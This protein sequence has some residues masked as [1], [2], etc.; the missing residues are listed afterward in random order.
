[1]ISQDKTQAP[2]VLTDKQVEALRDCFRAISHR[3]QDQAR[4][5]AGFDCALGAS[6]SG[7]R[8]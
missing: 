5:M 8:K 6:M 3:R 7:E 2:S 4:A 1:M